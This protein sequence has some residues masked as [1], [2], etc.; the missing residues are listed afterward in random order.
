[1]MWLANEDDLEELDPFN[2]LIGFLRETQCEATFLAVPVTD[3]IGCRQNRHKLS[4]SWNA[5][6]CQVASTSPQ[7][8][9]PCI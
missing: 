2:N 6:I 5:G 7:C 1:M 9:G 8:G 3:M 4:F